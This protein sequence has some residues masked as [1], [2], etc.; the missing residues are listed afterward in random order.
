MKIVHIYGQEFWHGSAYIIGNRS[1]MI[2]LREALDQALA[3]Q[4]AQTATVSVN[5][6]EGYFLN[7][8]VTDESEAMEIALPYT[9]EVAKEKKPKARWPCQFASIL[10]S[11][12]EAS[13]T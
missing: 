4:D 5:D 7:V 9:D 13:K 3:T 8:H 12:K 10:V 2:A 6:G 1:G 11:E